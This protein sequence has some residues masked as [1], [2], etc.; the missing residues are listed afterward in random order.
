MD[1]VR[2][3]R[4]GWTGHLTPRPDCPARIKPTERW[5]FASHSGYVL[6]NTASRGW[7]PA[8]LS[9]TAGPA[10]E[11]GP[12][13]TTRHAGR[14]LPRRTQQHRGRLPGPVG[15]RATG[16]RGPLVDHTVI[17]R[18]YQQVSHDVG[19]VKA[20]I[21]LPGGSLEATYAFQL[22]LRREYGRSVATSRGAIRF[23]A[24]HHSLDLL[25]QHRTVALPFGTLK[26]DAGL[27]GQFG[28]T[29]IQGLTLIPG[30]RRF[31]GGLFGFERLSIGNAVEFEVGAAS[32][33]SLK[34][35]PRPTRFPP[36]YVV[37]PSKKDCE[38]PEETVRCA[39]AW[40]NPC[41]SGAATSCP[42][43]SI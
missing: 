10:V 13:G 40:Q 27:K 19:L 6:G 4:S 29:C 39:T 12:P 41:P 16:N 18:P 35:V 20:D 43:T 36:T 3:S 23:H 37:G 24:A 9:A 31:S 21:D 28:K 1:C 22:G 30:F 25:F 17:D 15:R 2:T 38:E 8:E 14:D 7:N 33:D 5:E 11:S 42:T 26:G 32:M 34:Y